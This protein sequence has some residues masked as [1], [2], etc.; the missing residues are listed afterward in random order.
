MGWEEGQAAKLEIKTPPKQKGF[1]G[2]RETLVLVFCPR[3]R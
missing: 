3:V 1:V 2:Q